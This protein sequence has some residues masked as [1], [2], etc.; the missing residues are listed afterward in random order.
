MY[1]LVSVFSDLSSRPALA[2][3]RLAEAGVPVFACVPGGKRPLPGGR[4]F[5]DA[6]TELARVESWWQRVPNANLAVPTGRVSGV[7]AVDVDVHG[8]NG[9]DAFRRARDVGLLPRPLAVVRTPSGGMHL[10]YPADPGMEQRSW[11]AARAGIDFRGDG[12]YI[13]APPSRV[14]VDGV[15]RAYEVVELHADAVEP[16]DAA[17][18][19]GFLDPRPVAQRH[20]LRPVLS[21]AERVGRIVSWVGTLVEGERN[22]GLFWAACRL[23]EHGLAP[24]DAFDALRDP[25]QAVG[26]SEREVAVTVRSAYHTAQPAPASAATASSS[27][28][29][30]HSDPQRASP[31]RGLS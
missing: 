10:Y 25:A 27:G 3:D 7:V 1:P 28:L 2:A 9:F 19:R 12:G 30:V 16:V 23:A 15:L 24:S 14:R 31:A 5:L 6:T 11:Q 22:R 20:G 17:G 18:L 21:D 8:A 29:F 4:G 13:V 26:L